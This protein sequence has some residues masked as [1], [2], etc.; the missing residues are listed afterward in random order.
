MKITTK[1]KNKVNSLKR[2]EAIMFVGE[3]GSL[4]IYIKNAQIKLPSKAIK[5]EE[6]SLKKGSIIAIKIIICIH[7]IHLLN[8]Y[9]IFSLFLSFYGVLP[10]WGS[11]VLDTIHL[12]LPFFPNLSK[13]FLVWANDQFKMFN[14]LNLW[15]NGCTMNKKA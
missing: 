4:I 12:P 1:K 5:R 10:C 9:L 6:K 3:K 15:G 14:Y 7:I 8:I 2:S 11:W 13:F